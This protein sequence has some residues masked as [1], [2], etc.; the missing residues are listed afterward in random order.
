ML[1]NFVSFYEQAQRVVE[2]SDTTY[3]KVGKAFA[4]GPSSEL[5]LMSVTR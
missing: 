2:S 5:M 4:G 1:R 3:S